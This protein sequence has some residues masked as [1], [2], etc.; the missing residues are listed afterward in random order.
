MLNYLLSVFWLLAPAG[1]ANM[2]PTLMRWLP[3][4]DYPI[5]GG[6]KFRGKRLL[7]KN[8][9]VRGFVFGVL[10]GILGVY[11]QQITYP[12]TQGISWIIYPEINMWWLGFLL[13]F[14]ALLGDSVKSFFKRQRGIKPGQSWMP[15]DQIDWVIG[16]LVFMSFFKV[17]AIHIWI[18]SFFV[19][20][21]LHII[22]RFC[23]YQLS[24][25]K[26]KF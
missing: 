25:A 6:R 26:K 3:F 2:L 23:G 10:G 14:G 22:V 15:F 8:K 7:G 21:F 11:I 4:L 20:F 24:I 1:L 19:W 12:W 9:T 13:G 16:S 5:D 17:F 18:T